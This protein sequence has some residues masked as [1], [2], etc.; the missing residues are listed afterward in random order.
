MFTQEFRRGRPSNVH[1]A[2]AET[3]DSPM[4]EITD[5]LLAAF[6]DR[7]L[8]PEETARVAAALARNPAL[9]ARLAALCRAD[10]LV[11][12][13]GRSAAATGRRP[14]LR[15]FLATLILGNPGRNARGR[16][17]FRAG[18]TAGRDR[19]GPPS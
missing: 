4:T 9:A 3:G 16:R 11:R 17:R 15:P 18:R 12:A 6:A 14:T 2:D 5:A 1:P 13:A 8:G 7:E 19:G 10:A